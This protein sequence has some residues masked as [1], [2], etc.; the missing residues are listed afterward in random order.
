[1]FGLRLKHGQRYTIRLR[2]KM[3]YLAKA[4]CNKVKASWA[5]NVTTNTKAK[6]MP[7]SVRP[8]TTKGTYRYAKAEDWTS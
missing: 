8:G 6:E 7:T 5:C 2:P 1:M 4:N 3:R